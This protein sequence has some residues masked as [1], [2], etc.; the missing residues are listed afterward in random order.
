M[1][2][3]VVG[4]HPD[5]EL[6]GCGGTLLKRREEGAT[7]G[8]LNITSIDS[9]NGWLKDK[10]EKREGE[11]EQVRIQLGLTLEHFF[12]LGLP[13]TKLDHL[14]LGDIVEKISVA[15]Q[16][17]KPEEVFIPHS[18]DVHSDHRISFEAVLACTKWFRYPFVRKLLSY[19]TL[20]ETDAMPDVSRAF[21]PTVFVDI[22]K[23]LERKWELLQIYQSEMGE[24]PFPRSEKAVKALA[25]TRGA[26]SGFEAAE[27]FCLLRERQV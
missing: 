10:I 13:T 22:S 15:M 9:T 3:L 19:E 16:Q 8:W 17:F 2:V 5:D 24:F 20:S 7:I 11:I 1:R 18:G 23:H 4:P 25:W 27:A 12:Q 26:Q 21:Q 6:L 14:P